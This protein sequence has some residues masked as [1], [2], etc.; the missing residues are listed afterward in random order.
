M[1]LHTLFPDVRAQI[2]R[3]LF[4]DPA[5]EFYVRELTRES[6]LALRTV[7]KELAR[8]SAIELV[9][10]RSNGFHRFYRANSRHPAFAA[11]RQLVISDYRQT[12]FVNRHRRPRPGRRRR[13]SRTGPEFPS[14]ILSSA[15]FSRRII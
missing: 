12:A 13:I 2:V 7:Q 5:R 10:S 4:L 15:G 9:V 11:L 1:I 14:T 8:L 3:L 6:T